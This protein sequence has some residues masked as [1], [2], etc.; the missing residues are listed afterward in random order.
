MTLQTI[1]ERLGVSRMTVSN[2]FSQP[3]QLS[4]GLR[5]RILATADELGYVGPDPAARA[6]ARGATGAVGVLLT[7]SLK[8][9]FT[10][11]VARTFLGAIV[12]ELA[13]TGLALTL[14]TASGRDDVVPARD[15]ALDGA[16]VYSCRPEST[17]RDWLVRRRL[18]LVLVDQDPVPGV[19]TVN[20]DDRGGARAAAEHLLELGHRSIGIVAHVVDGIA[21]LMSEPHEMLRAHPQR[22]RLL[23]WMDALDTEAVEP[24][25]VNAPENTQ[26]SIG[27]ATR[28]LLSMPEVPTAVL[29][30][31][32]V[33]AF[34]VIDTARELGLRVPEDLSV[35]G[36]DDTA[37]ARRSSPP[38]TTVRQD[39]PAKGRA[40]AHELTKAISRSRSGKPS[41]GRPRRVLLPTELVVRQSTARPRTA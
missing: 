34:G 13:P 28:A 24:T 5:A 19:P 27:I 30:F 21:G 18:P 29:C 15:L 7:D 39:V 32:D 2:A 36:F 4:S 6:L 23:G 16:L 14:L 8:E 12:D 17:D 38:L 22:Q 33:V 41:A 20:V 3:D 10:D 9:A 31:S 40:A 26:Q 11:E 35:V 1:A 37:A 25:I